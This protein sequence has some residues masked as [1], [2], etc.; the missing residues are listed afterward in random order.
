MPEA[1]LKTAKWVANQSPHRM[2]P[3]RARS[4]RGRER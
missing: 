1:K 3:A 4:V 2:Y